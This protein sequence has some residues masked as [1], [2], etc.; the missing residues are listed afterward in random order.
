MGDPLRQ[1]RIYPEQNDRMLNMWASQV[2][3]SHQIS[4]YE[5]KHTFEYSR[6]V[7]TREDI[8]FFKD[9]DF[10]ELFH[11]YKECDLITKNCL[12]W[13][14]INM[15][16]HVYTSDKGKDLMGNRIQFY[17]EHSAFNTEIWEELQANHTL[18]KIC[19]LTID[20]IPVT[21]VRPMGSGFC[22][23]DFEVAKGCVPEDSTDLVL[24]NMCTDPANKTK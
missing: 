21:A 4:D 22:F 14:G 2:N 8:F 13:G 17:K 23:L 16:F 10:A 7:N 3:C 1:I 9:M 18:M 6:I 11:D 20:K 24:E 15:R 12:E 5:E 19:R